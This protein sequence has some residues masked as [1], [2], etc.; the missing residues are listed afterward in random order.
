MPEPTPTTD[1]ASEVKQKKIPTPALIAIVVG[2]VAIIFFIK[3]KKAQEES[4][5]QGQFVEANTGGQNAEAVTPQASGGNLVNAAQAMQKE[6]TEFLEHAINEENNKSKEGVKD[7]TPPGRGTGGGR[8]TE[9]T[10]SKGGRD[11]PPQEVELP[12][13]IEHPRGPRIGPVKPEPIKLPPGFILKPS[14]P[15]ID[16]A[17]I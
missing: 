8:G 15:P 12:K 2:G 10:G 4:S 14:I 16:R 13:E 11:I 9:I 6:N 1:V 7:K 17:K 3:H 5:N